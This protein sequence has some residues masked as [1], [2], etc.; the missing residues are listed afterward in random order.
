VRVNWTPACAAD[1]GTTDPILSLSK[2]ELRARYLF[3]SGTPS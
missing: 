1:A 2:H 3:V